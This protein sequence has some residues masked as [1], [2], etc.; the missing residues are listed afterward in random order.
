MAMMN[1]EP[2]WLDW[3]SLQ[4][5][6]INFLS[7]PNLSIY[8]IS[9]F[10]SKISESVFSEHLLNNQ[11][12]KDVVDMYLTGEINIEKS[13]YWNILPDTVFLN[14]NSMIDNTF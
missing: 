5:E 7:D 2:N 11:L 14:I 9:E 8:G 13:G 12:H 3:A 4:S 6:I 10:F 1:I